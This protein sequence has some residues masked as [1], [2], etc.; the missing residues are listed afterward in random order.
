MSPETLAFL[1]D[2]LS[3]GGL[4]VVGIILVWALLTDKIV[5]KGRLDE[6]RRLRQEIMAKLDTLIELLGKR[7]H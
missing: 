7:I 3:R 4:I 6:E 2:L 1:T 5:S